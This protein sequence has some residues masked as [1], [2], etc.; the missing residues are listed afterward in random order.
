MSTQPYR[1]TS[2]L[3]AAGPGIETGLAALARHTSNLMPV[4]RP[5]LPSSDEILPYLQAIDRR[6]WYSNWGPLVSQLEEQLCRHLAVEAGGVVTT[7]NATVG[8]TVALLALEAPRGSYCVMPS[9]TFAAT[10]HAALAAGLEPWFH[11]VDPRTWALDPDEVA[12]SLRGIHGRVGAV[13]VVSPFGAPIDLAAWEDFEERTGIRV[14]IDAA[15]SF[16]TAKPSRLPVVVSLH[17]TKI[18]PAGEGGFVATTDEKLRNR[19]MAC[20]NFG[21]RG[22]RSAILPSLNAKMS[23]YHAAV[24][25]ASLA[26]WPRTRA[27]H[28]QISEWYRESF[29]SIDAVEFQPGY[30][31]GWV[32]ST[33]SV[34]LP[35]RAPAALGRLLERNVESRP[36]WGAGCHV[37]PA[38]AACARGPLPVTEDL[39]KRVLGLPHYPDMRAQDIERVAEAVAEILGCCIDGAFQVA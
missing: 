8:L 9:W 22:S 5:K 14:V 31:T 21:F 28:A 35:A 38:F 23:E 17:A 37:Q 4:M 30:G 27:Q 18:L 24:A 29:R 11:D 39:G 34:V 20:C 19:M 10:P 2:D 1:P 16:D 7:A 3:M 12:G 26:N 36:W 6:Q 15:A 32:S 33:T 13:F 25:L